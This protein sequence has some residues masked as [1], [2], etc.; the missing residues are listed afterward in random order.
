MTDYELALLRLECIKL[1]Q[2]HHPREWEKF[3]TE[4]YNFL[5]LKKTNE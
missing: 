1:A 4:Y 2:Q 5:L 3:A